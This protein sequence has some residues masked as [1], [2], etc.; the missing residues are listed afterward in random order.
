[1]EDEEELEVL[2]DLVCEEERPHPASSGA[3]H[4]SISKEKEPNNSSCFIE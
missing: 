3:E 1:M 4:K 2:T